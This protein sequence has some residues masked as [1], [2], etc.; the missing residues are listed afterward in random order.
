MAAVN[1]ARLA[2][3]PLRV[4]LINHGS[5]TG[6]GVA[7]ST[8]HHEHLLNVAVRNMSAFPDQPNHFLDWLRTRSE[9]ADVP[10][11]E[12]RESFVPR[13]TYGDYLQ[14]LLFW[15]TK[16][17]DAPRARIE[18]VD[19]EVLDLVPGP[20]SVSIVV[21]QHA[22]IEADKVLLATGNP[23]PADL[24]LPEAF[25]HPRLLRNPWN[26]VDPWSIALCPRRRGIRS[27][28][29]R[30]ER[31]ASCRT[32][33]RIAAWRR[34]AP[35]WFAEIRTVPSERNRGRSPADRCRCRGP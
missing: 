12:L 15:Y 18:F 20:A 4:V 11:A 31:I 30:S 24:P 34:G 17:T 8:K 13:K 6:R 23:A 5:P 19:H 1:L 33:A 27:T 26:S 9:Y 21:K 22:T 10:E 25:E 2:N 3:V 28:L 7:Y 32:Y 29:S 14:S 16:G 35:R